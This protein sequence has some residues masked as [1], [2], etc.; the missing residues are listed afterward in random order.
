[1]YVRYVGE[2]GGISLE[3]GSVYPVVGNEP[4]DEDLVRIID[5]TECDYLFSLSNFKM[6]KDE[7]I[8]DLEKK[9]AEN[10]VK[11]CNEHIVTYGHGNF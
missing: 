11:K 6:L 4:L 10:L 3:K 9:K 1:L 2:N 8:N 7:E 5:E